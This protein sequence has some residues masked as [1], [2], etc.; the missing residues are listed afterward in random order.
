MAIGPIHVEWLSLLARKGILRAPLSLLDLGPQDVQAPR[1]YIAEVARRHLDSA[2]AFQVEEG[3]FDGTTPRADG[4]AAFYRMFGANRYASVDLN[5][6]RATF[7]LDLNAPVPDIGTYDVITN[8]G[9]VE[10][11]FD[12]GEAFR[13]IHRLLKPEGV[14]LH[15]MPAFAFIDHGFYNVHP[16]FFLELAKANAYEV[17]DFSYIDNMFVRNSRHVRGVFDFNALPVKLSDVADTQAFMTKVVNLFRKNLET[18]PSKAV[19]GHPC[20]VFDLLFVALRRTA[21]SPSEL[22]QAIQGGF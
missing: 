4:Q 5:D 9:T 19:H 20:F 18:T 13:S 1:S 17:V 21:N 11:V 12:I 22:R 14:S 10:H 15:C 3:V 6:K 7:S 2:A 16:S 8:F